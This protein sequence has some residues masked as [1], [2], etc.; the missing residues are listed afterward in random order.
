MD[1]SSCLNFSYPKGQQI[2]L[3]NL[4]KCP[5]E[6][7]RRYLLFL[8]VTSLLLYL[9]FKDIIALLN[10]KKRY[11]IITL[12]LKYSEKFT[13]NTRQNNTFKAAI[14]LPCLYQFFRLLMQ[15]I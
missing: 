8:T 14:E 4:L 7:K 15:E 1:I 2:H 10:L 6:K 13:I 3:F 11:F 5:H 9:N 12:K